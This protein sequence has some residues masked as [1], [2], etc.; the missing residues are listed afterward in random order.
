[1]NAAP[2][3]TLAEVMNR[4][5]QDIIETIHNHKYKDENDVKE[6]IKFI[7][8]SFRYCKYTATGAAFGEVGVSDFIIC[9]H[10]YMICVEAKCKN[11]GGNIFADDKSHQRQFLHDE[12]Q[13]G[14]L[15]LCIDEH[16]LEL[17][18]SCMIYVA[19]YKPFA[20]GQP[21]LQSSSTGES[22]DSLRGTKFTSITREL[23]VAA[24][25]TRRDDIEWD[26]VR[27]SSTPVD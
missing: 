14:A 19:T 27:L 16:S 4:S 7:C 15:S 8:K 3:F 11:T 25:F 10:G 18:M 23:Q 9:L 17:L 12:D 6:I 13:A 24:T 22:A 5:V 2:L 26:M 1:M 20:G 21:A